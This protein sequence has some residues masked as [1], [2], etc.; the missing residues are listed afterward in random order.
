[1][2]IEPNSTTG[3]LFNPLPNVPIAVLDPLTMT[4]SFM[5][6]PSLDKIEIVYDYN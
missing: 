4:T 3:T 5:D 1:M 6:A 2:T